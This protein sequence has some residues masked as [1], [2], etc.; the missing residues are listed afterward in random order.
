MLCAHGIVEKDA[1]HEYIAAAEGIGAVE[2][3]DEL[4]RLLPLQIDGWGS[5]KRR[6]A[7]YRFRDRR[8]IVRRGEGT[9]L[10]RKVPITMEG[11]AAIEAPA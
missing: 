3:G 1:R 11:S 10:A 4:P 8:R 5:G 2:A 9:Y 6:A 7:M